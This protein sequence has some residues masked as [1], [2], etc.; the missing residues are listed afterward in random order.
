M[1]RKAAVKR[2][3]NVAAVHDELELWQVAK[4]VTFGFVRVSCDVTVSH[5]FYFRANVPLIVYPIPSHSFELYFSCADQLANE[6]P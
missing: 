3:L 6:L 4:I 1:Y 5:N 2:L